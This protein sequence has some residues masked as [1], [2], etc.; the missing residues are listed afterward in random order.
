MAMNADVLSDRLLE[1][2]GRIMDLVDALPSKKTATHCANQLLRSGTAPG[3]NYE[4][5]RAAESRDDFIHKC[6][7]VLKELRESRY[8]IR[9]VSRKNF[10]PPRSIESLLQESN[11]LI[12]IF[13]KSISTARSN[14]TRPS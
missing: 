4:E 6:R 7:I 2:A 3:A 12:M 10:V 9:L 1:F 13:S 8:W 11:E 5:A 14:R